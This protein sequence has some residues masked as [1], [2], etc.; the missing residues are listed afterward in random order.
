MFTQSVLLVSNGNSY[1]S[2]QLWKLKGKKTMI[3]HVYYNV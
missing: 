3:D 1:S 2:S